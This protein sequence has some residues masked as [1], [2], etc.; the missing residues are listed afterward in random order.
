MN[1][2]FLYFAISLLCLQSCHKKDS[3]ADFKE[4]VSVRKAFYFEPSTLRMINLQE[5][6]DFNEM[7]KNVREGRYYIVDINQ[8][9]DSAVNFLKEEIL[10][11]GYEELMSIKSKHNDIAIYAVEEKNPTVVAIARTDT[12]YNIVEMQGMI[13]VVKIP[14]ILD[15]FKNNEFLNIL[16]LSDKKKRNPHIEPDTTSKKPQ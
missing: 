12:V 5:N 15:T 11:E 2:L 8:H 1:K 7:V 14:K 9:A 13:N 10:K 6:E 16:S 3:L 4:R